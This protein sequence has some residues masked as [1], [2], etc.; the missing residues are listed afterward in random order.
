V[1][2]PDARGA[3]H[4]FGTDALVEG[5]VREHHVALLAADAAGTGDAV[6]G[7]PPPV[8][9]SRVVIGPA[10]PVRES[11]SSYA[12]AVRLL[13]LADR[14]MVPGAQ[15]LRACDHWLAL[16]LDRDP[17]LMGDVVQ[18]R[19]GALLEL[20]ERRR[21]PMVETLT[22]WLARP[23]QISAIA[24][25]LHVHAQTVRY[26]LDRLRELVGPAIDDPEQ[27]LELALATHAFRRRHLGVPD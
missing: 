27:R 2:D 3:R 23:G 21:E 20:S 1:V 24:D 8:G 22:A 14:G 11:R 9:M 17:H 25:E 19:L 15:V 16:L 18:R 10:V 4:S 6:P 13:E 12:D 26:R 7:T 5:P